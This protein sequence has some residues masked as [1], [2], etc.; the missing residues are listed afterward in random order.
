MSEKQKN[1]IDAV[2]IEVE[3]LK[4]GNIMQK[5]AGKY[6]SNYDSFICNTAS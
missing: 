5:L 4:Q 3:V 1:I 6:N 2:P